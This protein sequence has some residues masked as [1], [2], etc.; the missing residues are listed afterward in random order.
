MPKLYYAFDLIAWIAMYSLVC[1]CSSQGV[2]LGLSPT[3]PVVL[4]SHHIMRR[5][6]IMMVMALSDQ[7][8]G[9]HLQSGCLLSGGN[10]V[11]MATA[12]DR[13]PLSS[14]RHEMRRGPTMAIMPA[15]LLG[16]GG[17]K[18]KQRESAMRPPVITNNK[19]MKADNKVMGK[20]RNVH[21][22]EEG[23]GQ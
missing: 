12:V 18:K 2:S 17:E 22:D 14:H 15:L 11:M 16:R 20:T 3:L 7:A 9:F 4:P 5:F 21:M 8:I 10:R 13:H 1:N 23:R 6:L 19:A